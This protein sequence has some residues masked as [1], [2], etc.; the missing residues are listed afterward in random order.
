[1][2]IDKPRFDRAPAGDDAPASRHVATAYAAAATGSLVAEP[3]V[4]SPTAE[5]APAIIMCKQAKR[6][7]AIARDRG[8]EEREIELLLKRNGFGNSE[9]ITRNECDRHCL[10]MENPALL[11]EIRGGIDQA[12]VTEPEEFHK[13]LPF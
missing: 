2:K 13:E 9:E 12:V 11:A 3:A 6:F 10:S 8:Y 7:R 4:V 1:M 5:R